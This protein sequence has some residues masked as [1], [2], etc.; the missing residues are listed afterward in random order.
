MDPND[1]RVVSS[2]IVQ[3]LSGSDLTVFGDGS[4]TRAFCYVDDLIRGLILLM[5]SDKSIVGP[6]NLGNP[7][8]FSVLQLAEN[9][10]RKLGS[11][12]SISYRDIPLDDPRQRLPDISFAEQSLGWHPTVD[13][14]A[15]LDLTVAYFKSIEVAS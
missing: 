6:M 1:G 12:S 13:L 10:L 2:F 9:I 3:A 14:Q 15:G 8:E 5:N 11:K 7:E 4:Q